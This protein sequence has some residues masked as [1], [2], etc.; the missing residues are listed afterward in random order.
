MIPYQR[1]MFK[2]N[3][4]AMQII[5]ND[6]FYVLYDQLNLTYFLNT[7]KVALKFIIHI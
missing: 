6:R 4:F 3:H 2:N 5:S 1:K 7:G